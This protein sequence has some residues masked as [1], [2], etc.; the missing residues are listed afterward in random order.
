MALDEFTDPVDTSNQ[1]AVKID[2]SVW[3]ML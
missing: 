1:L 2:V 3:Y